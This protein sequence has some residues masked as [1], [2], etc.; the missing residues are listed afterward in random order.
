MF[1]SVENSRYFQTSVAT[2]CDRLSQSVISCDFAS[3]DRLHSQCPGI[4]ILQECA[5]GRCR[6]HGRRC[7]RPAPDVLATALR[8][9]AR[10]RGQE[11]VRLDSGPRAKGVGQTHQ[12]PV[13]KYVGHPWPDMT[14]TTGVRTI[15]EAAA[16]PKG[17]QPSNYNA[18]PWFALTRSIGPLQT[19]QSS[20]RNPHARFIQTS[21]L[22]Y[23]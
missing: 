16:A 19:P 18:W 15:G 21:L 8:R 4:L 6:K 9:K 23:T 22:H 10:A 3:V 13:P 12:L 20:D 1:R 11:Q 5:S 7:S 14:W 17:E 2:Y